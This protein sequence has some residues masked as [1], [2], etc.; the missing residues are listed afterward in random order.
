VSAGYK[1][2]GW[3]ANK[4]KYDLTVLVAVLLFITSFIMV[5]ASRLHG[6]EALSLII[7]LMRTFSTCAFLMLSLL[8]C[9]GPLARMSPRFLPLLYNR[10]H[11][12]VM[13]FVVALLHAALA[14]FWYHSFGVLNPIVSVFTSGGDYPSP[15]RMPFQAF[16]AIALLIMFLMA[17]TSHDYWN[18]NLGAPVWKALHMLVYPAYL[19]LVAH[20]AF[21]ALQQDNTG[22]T[23]ALLVA[24]SG[25]VLILHLASFL[26]YSSADVTVATDTDEWVEACQWQDIVNNRGITVDIGDDERVAIFRYDEN[27]LCAVAN[28]CQ[29]QN[30]PLGEGCVINGNIVCP[31]HGYEYLPENGRSPA[32]FTEKIPT[33]D[34]RLE[35]DTVLV[36][37]QANPAGTNREVI[38]IKAISS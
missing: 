15:T 13:T 19:L 25:L 16:G 14:I 37:R 31:W 12:G 38:Q 5:T 4:K 28:A 8:L 1:T 2:V 29:H 23:P 30:G 9:I 24:F 26:R 3:N 20:I 27:R 10:R 17:S 22:F 6:G 11:F 33:Y 34:L 21:G 7:V 32:P 35:G 36:K 18:K